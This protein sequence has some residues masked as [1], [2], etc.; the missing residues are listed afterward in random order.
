[1]SIKIQRKTKALIPRWNSF[2][3]LHCD[4][5]EKLNAGK[6]VVMKKLSKFSELP[7]L[8]KRYIKEV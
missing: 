4:I 1:M 3:G 2:C 6:I 5:W 7:S 8:A